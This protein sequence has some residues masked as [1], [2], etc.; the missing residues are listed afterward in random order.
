MIARSVHPV[1]VLTGF[2][3]LCLAADALGGW[4]ASQS[5]G[6]WYPALIRPSRTP[7]PWI[8]APVWTVLYLAMAL[9][10]WLVWR[11]DARFSGVRIALNL[12][13]LQLILNAAWPFL[14]FGLR[15][16]GWALVDIAA[17][18]IVLAL[19]VWAFFGQSRIAGLLMLVYLVWVAFAAAL[20]FSIWRLN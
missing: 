5:V 6:N 15:S 16:P 12:F 2:A 10:A 11:K 18:L 3:A 4:A 20:N 1:L 9:A 14:F 13:F 8:F 19:T 17:L 7:P